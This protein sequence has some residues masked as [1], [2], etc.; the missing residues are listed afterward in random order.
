M[1]VAEIDVKGSQFLVIVVPLVRFV[2]I[3]SGGLP[4]VF[5]RYS[6]Y[7]DGKVLVSA[8][9]TSCALAVVHVCMFG[10]LIRLLWLGP[11]DRLWVQTLLLE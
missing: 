6:L 5:G 4:E 7:D 1:M 3:R 2:Y 8:C 11:S 10:L 9:V